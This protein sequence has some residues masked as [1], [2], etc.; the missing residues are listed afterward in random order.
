MEKFRMVFQYFQSN[1]ESVMNGICGL[2]ALGS[3]KIYTSFDFNCPCMPNYNMAYGMGIMFIPPMILFF[4]GLIL[5]K[6]SLIILEELKRPPGPRKK[7]S[8]VLRYM[9]FAM[10]QRAMVAP[11]IWIIIALLDGKC[12]ICAFSGSVETQKFGGLSNLTGSELQLLLAKVPCKDDEIMKDNPYRKAVSRYL[13]CWSQGIG[14]SILLILIMVA[15]IARS[16]KPCFD[17]A[18]FLQTRYWSN[19]LDLE[20]K[21]F[22]ETC[23]EH[24]RDFARKCIIQFFESMHEELKKR[25]EMKEGE[26]DHLHGITNC[27]QMNRLLKSWYRSKPALDVTQTVQRQQGKAQVTISWDDSQSRSWYV[28][29]DTGNSKQSHV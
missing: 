19:Y 27:E 15:V 24:A 1:S 21:I 10:T 13:R 23:C 26:E 4:L 22:D 12:V 28:T 29:H 3:V 25:E 2:L 6:Q 5:N 8:S 14:W 9:F 7:N 11:V 20:Q 18:A 17:H 16:L